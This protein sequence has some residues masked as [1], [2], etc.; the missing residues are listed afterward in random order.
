MRIKS[1]TTGRVYEQEDMVY[2][3]NPVQIAK[4][5]KYGITLYD[6]DESNGRLIGVFSRRETKEVY[7][8]WQNKE[9]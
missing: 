3:V 2:L 7:N 4:Y 1:V 8:K 6:L 5:I 9:I